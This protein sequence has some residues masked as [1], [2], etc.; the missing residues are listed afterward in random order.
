M[1]DRYLD[2]LHQYWGYPDFRGIQRD[3]IESIGAGKDTLGLMP[4]GGGKS[5]TFQVPALAAEGVCIVVTP[6]IALMKDQVQH[7][8]EK[9]IDAQAIYSGMTHGEILKTL[10]NCAYGHVKLLYVSPERLGTDLFMGK[11]GGIR[12]SF[13]TVDEAHCISQWGYDFRPSYLKIA[14]IRSLKPDAPVL[15]L[16]ATATPKVADDIQEKLRFR[17]KNVFRMSFDRK[18]LAYVVRTTTNKPAEMVHI[19]N[20]V[21]GSAIVYAYTRKHVRLIAEFLNEQGI[22]ATFYH[23]GLDPSVKDQRQK[24]WQQGVTRVIVATNAFGMGI[25]KPDVRL[26]IHADCPE[27]IE[28]YFQEAGR[29]GRDGRKAYAVLLYDG[30][31]KRTLKKRVSDSFPPK[32]YVRNV[33]EHLAYFFQIAIGEGRGRTC[34]FRLQ[35]FCIAYHMAGVLV[36]SSLRILQRCGY[37]LY[38]VDPHNSARLKFLLNRQ[39][40]YLLDNLSPTEDHVITALFR[41]YCGLF[42]DY[43][44]IDESLVAKTAGTDQQHVYIILRNLSKRRIVD[45]I[46][47]RKTPYIT[48]LT[49]RVDGS[50]VVIPREAYE[51]R[52]KQYEKRIGAMLE[53]ATN[54]EVCRPRQLLHY[55]GESTI[56]DCGQCDVCLSYR[57]RNKNL[58]PYRQEI[59]NLLNDKQQHHITELRALPIPTEY[60]KAALIELYHEEIVVMDGSLIK[61][62]V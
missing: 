23:A 7:M 3:I 54:D 6:L 50:D 33:Y 37:I 29:A 52:K 11:L 20:S 48:Y 15:A 35:E 14:D 44:Y 45:F 12:V 26:V 51:T 30:S 49:D 24:D 59:L 41:L 21:D 18:N 39:E 53:Y 28:A 2:I 56:H 8:R 47:Q 40:L 5:V 10:E 27:S 13:I 22:K 38:E 25:D 46:P 1:A 61:S 57:N 32:D 43:V 9:G 58:A 55:F 34:E 42:S 19:L 36:D 17:K 60:L 16:T 4:T 62:M 31:D